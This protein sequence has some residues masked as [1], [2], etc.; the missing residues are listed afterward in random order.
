M[1]EFIPINLKTHKSILI[2]LNDEYLN[3]IADE[4][5][6]HYNIDL[7]SV[8][9]QPIRNY[10]ENSVKELTSYKPPNGIFYILQI[11]DAMVGMGAFRKLNNHTGEVKRMYL[12]QDFRG[13]GFG[14]ALLK[15]LLNNG[16]EFGCSRVLLDTGQ[17]MTAAQKVYRSAGFKE[18][19]KYPETE[20]PLEIQKYWIYMEVKLTK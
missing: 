2:D 18:I 5:R 14:K 7:V 16:K 17:F 4:L 11:E 10:A 15:K 19:E 6:I 8:L 13:R 20:V 1:I 3:W 9:G 12:R